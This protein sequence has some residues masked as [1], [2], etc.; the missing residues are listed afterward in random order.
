MDQ[1]HRWLPWLRGIYDDGKPLWLVR[2][3]YV[4]H[5]QREV[6]HYITE[7]GIDLRFIPPRLTDER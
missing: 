5:R 6:K 3:C 1:F 7:L 4:V 2:G